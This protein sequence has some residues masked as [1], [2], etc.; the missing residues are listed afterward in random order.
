MSDV[1][2]S[3]KASEKLA[4][5]MDFSEWMGDDATIV[6]I[7]SITSVQC[8]GMSSDLTFSAQ[9]ITGQTAGFFVEGGTAGLRYEVRVNI[10]TNEGE[11][12]EGD[13]ILVVT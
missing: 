7:N 3:K 2:I 10:T 5:G 1:I 13:G 11:I 12:L 6:T 4:V 9:A 8:A